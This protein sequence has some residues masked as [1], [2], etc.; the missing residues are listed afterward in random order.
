M[1]TIFS[2]TAY[3]ASSTCVEQIA[4]QAFQEVDRLNNLMS[5]YRP[6][7]ELSMLNREALGRSVVLTPELFDVLKESLH[8]SVETDGAFDITVGQLM[9]SWG[10]FQGNEHVPSQ[11]ELKDLLRRTG[12]RHVELNAAKRSIQFDEPGIELDLGAIGK[13]YAVDRV[14]EILRRKELDCALISSGMSSIYALGAPPGESG[15]GISICDPHDRRKKACSLQL[16]DLSV[17]ISGTHEK[18]FAQNGKMYTHILH[19]G[20]GSPADTMLMSVVI[21]DSS[22]MSDALSTAFFVAGPELGRTYLA[23]HSDT[24]AIFYVRNGFSASFDEITLHSNTAPLPQERFS[25][26]RISTTTLRGASCAIPMLKE[27]RWRGCA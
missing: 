23:N 10:F 25:Q 19:P 15:W 24:A 20:S 27:E 6:N 2:I 7:S 4:R 5:R 16:R 14:A 26:S 22:T 18:S 3:G 8:L 12:Y 17:S 13:G 11:A 1:G 9:R 21:T